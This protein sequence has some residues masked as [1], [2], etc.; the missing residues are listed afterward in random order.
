[1]NNLNNI[2]ENVDKPVLIV[3]CGLQ[4]SGKSTQALVFEKDLQ[5]NII[6]SDDIRQELLKLYNKEDIDEISN[7]EVFR[8]VYLRLN[9]S[10]DVNR[11]TIFDATNTT[12]KVRRQL[13][14]NIKKDCYKIC[15]IM[16]TTYH[17][18][19]VNL[20]IRNNNSN[21]KVPEEILEKYYYSFQIPFYNEG[22]DNIILH[23]IIEE[24]DSLKTK[25]VLLRAAEG[26]DQ[27][28]KHHTQDLG[29]H[30]K[31]V[32]DILSKRTTNKVLIE[33]GYYH[34]I[35]KLFTQTIGNDNQ[36]HY[37]NHDSVGAYNLMC[38]TAYYNL[39]GEYDLNIFLKWLFYINYHMTLYQLK[40]EKSVKKWKL[41]FGED[42]YN[43]LLLLQEVDKLRVEEI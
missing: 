14:S 32:G 6:S 37:Y 38:S 42:L 11:V 31:F 27:R 25:D 35:G 16:N 3:M 4:G 13:F 33:A 28:N 2:L 12:V 17:N 34:D 9:E 43:D 40:T 36:C 7:E 10:L 8:N 19:L 18:C 24:E 30:M 21:Y 15:Y 1:M 41:L 23:N 22:W 29:Q 39:L 20:N 26:F 5:G